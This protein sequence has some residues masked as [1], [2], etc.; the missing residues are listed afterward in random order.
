[1]IKTRALK[2]IPGKAARRLFVIGLL[3]LLSSLQIVWASAA[4]I[5]QSLNQSEVC[6]CVHGCNSASGMHP[7]S[8]TRSVLDASETEFVI[9]RSDSPSRHSQSCCEPQQQTAKPLVALINPL[10]VES[11]N[12]P[13][14]VT[15]VALAVV[16]AIKTHDPPHSRPLYVTHSCLLI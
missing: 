2:G 10:S 16:H 11:E 12:Y 13:T 6:E 3:F 1:M 15:S 7:E 14:I 5:Y 8:M 4:C 9:T